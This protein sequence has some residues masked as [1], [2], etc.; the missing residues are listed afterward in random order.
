MKALALCCAVV[1]LALGPGT[2]SG[3]EYTFDTDVQVSNS[4]CGASTNNAGQH[5]I[6]VRG[7]FV[8]LVW[9]DCR[10]PGEAVYF[11]RSTDGGVSFAPETSISAGTAETRWPRLD[12]DVGGNT[13]HVA[14]SGEAPG[15]GVP[16]I[17]YARST[18]CG[19]S[20]T[21]PLLLG[22]SDGYQ[23]FPCLGT[24]GEDAVYVI[25]MHGGSVYLVRSMDRGSCPGI[26]KGLSAGVH[27]CGGRRAGPVQH[28]RRGPA[29][30]GQGRRQAGDRPASD[31]HAP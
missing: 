27:S 25:W 5:T 13:V 7:D 9:A 10:D 20:F 30:C 19:A 16:G 18:D 29:E 17:Y 12:A 15:D 24:D 8:Y 1:C 31:D 22:Q 21:E 11:T 3:A 2:S 28:H 26:S 14:W 23:D 4:P 6:A